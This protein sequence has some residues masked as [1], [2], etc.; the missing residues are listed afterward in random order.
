MSEDNISRIV[1]WV[2]FERVGEAKGELIRFLAPRT[3][4]ALLA[5]LPLRGRIS[6]SNAQLYFEVPLK[7]GYEKAVSKVREGDVAYWPFGSSLCF[8]KKEMQP[9]RPMNLVGKMIS[10]TE[11]FQNVVSG[12]PVKIERSSEAL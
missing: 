10:G 4:D 7:M 11:L 8:F 12:T 2:E 9:Y 3:V 6:I 1:F 5:L